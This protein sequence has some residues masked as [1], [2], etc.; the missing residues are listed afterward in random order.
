[1]VDTRAAVVLTV[2]NEAPDRLDQAVR[3][4]LGQSETALD[5]VIVDDG[6]TNPATRACLQRLAQRDGR[7]RLERIA[8]QGPGGAAN[9]GLRL[10]RAPLV[11]RHDS[12][13]WSDPDRFARQIAHM[14]AH[15]GLV[16]LGTG[17]AWHQEDGTAI[18]RWLCP[19]D[20]AAV[21]AAFSRS[22]PMTHGSLCLR[23]EAVAAIG[24][25][26]PQLRYG[27]DYDLCW[28]L[29]EV[30]DGANLPDVLYHHRFHVGSVSVQHFQDRY[31]Y[32][33]AVRLLAKSRASGQEI[34][35]ADALHLAKAQD[36]SASAVFTGLG[37]DMMRAGRFR[38][39]LRAYL[40]GLARPG[41]PRD[42][43]IAGAKL[44]RLALF[45]ASP[46]LRQH[47]FAE[48]ARKPAR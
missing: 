27:E 15:P 22:N 48:A 35:V 30:G 20:P 34:S 25:Y 1:M 36:C 46:R 7:I 6:S 29:S 47:L 28:R 38:G 16:M 4:I 3:S 37:D 32:R 44:G 26:R 17:I 42:T 10:V 45:A 12:D 18:A 5:I 9:A 43:M 39:A 11:F 19:P 33:T 41:T 21:R 40:Q 8:N 14:E 24:G 31:R 2:Y 13:D 23:R